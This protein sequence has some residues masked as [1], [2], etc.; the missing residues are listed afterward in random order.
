[1]KKVSFAPFRKRVRAD[2]KP[3]KSIPVGD[4]RRKQEQE[5][6]CP[7]PQERIRASK[8]VKGCPTAYRYACPFTRSKIIPLKY[9]IQQKI[10]ISY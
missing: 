6:K 9:K 3:P 1:M 7:A 5:H 2:S 8:R 4:P 10:Y